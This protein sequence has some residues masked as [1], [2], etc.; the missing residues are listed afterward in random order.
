[1]PL[2][3]PRATR[4]SLPISVMYRHPH[5][6]FWFSS[7]AVNLSESG[8]LFWPADLPAG[9]RVEVMLSP[10]VPLGTLAAGPQICAGEVVR[11]TEAGAAAV[12]FQDSRLLL[13]S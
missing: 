3:L 7:R 13:E 4:S 5:D 2:M 10:P 1:M 8:V 6:D 12:R 9:A 11:T